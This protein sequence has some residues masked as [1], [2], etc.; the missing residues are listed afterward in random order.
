MLP[1]FNHTQVFKTQR[2]NDI[3]M[4][5]GLGPESYILP[6]NMSIEVEMCF[7]AEKNQVQQNGVIFNALTDVSTKG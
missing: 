6:I 7:I 2:A 3:M 1:L 4:R 5:F